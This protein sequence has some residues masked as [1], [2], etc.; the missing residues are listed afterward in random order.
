LCLLIN[1]I[2]LDGNASF[3]LDALRDKDYSVVA[4]IAKKIVNEKIKF[5]SQEFKGA[6]LD[7]KVEK[8]DL[9]RDLE[10]E[11]VR[12]EYEKKSEEKEKELREEYEEKLKEADLS[13]EEKEEEKK[14]LEEEIGEWNNKFD[15]KVDK[16]EKELE[17]KYSTIPNLNIL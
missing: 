12:S 11:K 1:L 10:I 4:K 15:E 3:V 5:G 8:F 14:K 7:G 16:K 17:D 2:G 6:I 9:Q 13:K